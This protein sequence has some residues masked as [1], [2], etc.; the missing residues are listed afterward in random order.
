MFSTLKSGRAR[1]AVPAVV[2]AVIASTAVAF[3][4]TGASAQ[5]KLPARSAAQLLTAVQHAR[6]AGLSGTVVSTVKLVL[7]SVPDVPGLPRCGLTPEPLLGG[8]QTL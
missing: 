7:P 4:S 3:H 8:S 6:P 1:W 2:A 5:P